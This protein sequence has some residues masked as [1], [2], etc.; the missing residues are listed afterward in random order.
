MGFVGDETATEDLYEN[1]SSFVFAVGLLGSESNG[2]GDGTVS[3]VLVTLLSV[4]PLLLTVGL[5]LG[6]IAFMRRQ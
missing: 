2:G 1:E 3:P 5:V 4:I 6:A